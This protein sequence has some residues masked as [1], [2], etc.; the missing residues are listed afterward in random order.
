MQF[1]FVEMNGNNKLSDMYLVQLY[2]CVLNLF[3]S[4]NNI[5]T[6]GT[7]GKS[8]TPDSEKI[9]KNWEKEGKIRKKE[10][11]REEKAKIRKVLSLCPSW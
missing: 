1:L 3:I 9:V 10:E 8:A 4:V 6:G 5:A 7:G 2:F 11:T